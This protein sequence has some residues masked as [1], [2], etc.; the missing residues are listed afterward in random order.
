ML[1]NAPEGEVM[2]ADNTARRLESDVSGPSDTN[3]DI[4]SPSW[5]R[6]PDRPARPARKREAIS[7][8]AIVNGAIELLDATAWMP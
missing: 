4:S 2:M 3:H 6:P 5:R 1:K 7:H 8:T